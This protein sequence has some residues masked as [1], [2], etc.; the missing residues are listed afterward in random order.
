MNVIIKKT[1]AWSE[2]DRCYLPGWIAID[3]KTNKKITHAFIG[4]YNIGHSEVDRMRLVGY[5]TQIRKIPIS[6]IKFNDS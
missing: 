2:E 5:L 6:N 3:S 4:G 1:I